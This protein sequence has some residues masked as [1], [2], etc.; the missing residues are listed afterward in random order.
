MPAGKMQEPAIDYIKSKGFKL[1]LCDGDKNAFLKPKADIFLCFDIFD[2]NKC[3]NHL[4]E[5]KKDLNIV[6]AFTASSDCH[7]SISRLAELLNSKLTWDSKISEICSDKYKTR[8]FLKNLCEQPKFKLLSSFD[9][10]L[11]S[12]EFGCDTPVV[13]KAIDSSGSRGFQS[14][15]SI[16]EISP[17][18]FEYTKSFSRTDEI[19][20]EEKLERSEKFIS[21]LSV[22]AIFFQ[23][24]V[25]ITN[26]VDRVFTHDLKKFSILKSLESFNPNEAIEFGHFN[27]SFLN[28]DII[29]KIKDQFL[30]IFKSFSSN[31][32]LLTLKLDILIDKHQNPIVLEMTPRTSGGWDSCFSNIAIGGN[33]QKIL[34]DFLLQQKNEREIFHEALSFS[35]LNKRIFIL[36]VPENNS[37]N[38]IGRKFYSS[39]IMSLHNS[40]EI[41]LSTSLNNF[42]KGRE[43]EPIKII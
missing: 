23:D 37:P 25:K 24:S 35:E 1:I 7:Y 17:S 6:G 8:N 33:L 9:D 36:A 41:F 34:I 39:D 27:P 3:L 5:Y 16:D 40:A 11:L 15:S 38:C 31:K 2:S 26:M 42:N 22:E 20:V 28:R 14:F 10:L 30:M 19:L 4:Q 29:K 21:E 18:N 12:R 43:I 32:D 13:L